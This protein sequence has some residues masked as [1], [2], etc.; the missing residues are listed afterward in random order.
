MHELK[1]GGDAASCLR[2]PIKGYWV[3]NEPLAAYPRRDE[4]NCSTPPLLTYSRPLQINHQLW[5]CL[6]LSGREK[7]SGLWNRNE[8]S[9]DTIRQP[10]FWVWKRGFHTK[11]FRSSRGFLN[12]S[13]SAAA[14]SAPAASGCVS[15]S[16]ERGQILITSCGT[17]QTSK[18]TSSL[19]KRFLEILVQ[20]QP[21]VRFQTP[22]YTCNFL[23]I[24]YVA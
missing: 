8:A 10:K 11:S 14:D 16:L 21:E 22:I 15:G 23:L 4:L 6:V 12:S 24:N 2:L 20:T 7:G 9:I 17:K 13:K 5:F 18:T 3:L 19:P 1:E